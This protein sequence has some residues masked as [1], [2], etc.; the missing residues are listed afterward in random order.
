[1][2]LL[3]I[4]MFKMIQTIWNYT[5]YTR[6][7][8]IGLTNKLIAFVLNVYQLVYPLTV[9][10]FI[11]TSDPVC[12]E[13]ILFI[14]QH[15]H[16]SWI[17][18][19]NRTILILITVAQ[20]SMLQKTHQPTIPV[21]RPQPGD[22]DCCHWHQ[23]VVNFSILDSSFEWA[24]APHSNYYIEN[25]IPQSRILSCVLDI[26]SSQSISSLHPATQYRTPQ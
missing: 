7:N 25:S 10:S 3:L 16:W 24:W 13:H 5:F 23:V 2:C 18:G 20:P 17:K 19:S 11:D 1:M 22:S 4:N 21:P 26:L 6:F 8:N 12:T 15:D 9:L 14:C